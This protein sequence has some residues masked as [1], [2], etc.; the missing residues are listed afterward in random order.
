MRMRNIAVILLVIAAGAWAQ[1]APAPAPQPKIPELAGLRADYVTQL[2]G[3]ETKRHNYLLDLRAEYMAALTSERD[4]VQRAGD[5]A[6]LE[7]IKEEIGRFRRFRNWEFDDR[8]YPAPEAARQICR[9]YKQRW[10]SMEAGYRSQVT[11]LRRDLATKLEALT[12]RL[13]KENR[14][15]DAVVVR[16]FQSSIPNV[17]VEPD[18]SA[19]PMPEGAVDRGIANPDSLARWLEGSVWSVDWLGGDALRPEE[20]LEFRPGDVVRSWNYSRERMDKRTYKIEKN[21]SLRI[22]DYRLS[23]DPSATVCHIYDW[24]GNPWRRA[25]LTKRLPEPGPLRDDILLYYNFDEV[26]PRVRDQSGNGHDATATTTATVHDGARKFACQF[27][28]RESGIVLDGGI[29]PTNHAAF[30]VAMWVRAKTWERDGTVMHWPATT[31][32][33]GINAYFYRDRIRF[34]IGSPVDE[35][36]LSA[37]LAPGEW[38]HYAFTFDRLGAVFLYRDGLEVG[39]CLSAPPGGVGGKLRIGFAAGGDSYRFAG[40]VDEFFLFKRALTPTDVRTIVSWGDVFNAE[41]EPAPEPDPAPAKS[42]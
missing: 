12:V 15:E 23:F 37:P 24:R 2:R 33:G 18:T 5:L 9:A 27:D 1:E 10:E 35:M 7:Q 22:S 8:R 11:P 25:R 31:K 34:R 42:E 29:V 20:L 39:R 3:L 21:L 17:K 30:S 16:D 28:G 40:E 26:S 6:R 38:H 41:P 36:D 4:R 14:V 19:I 32:R 13:T